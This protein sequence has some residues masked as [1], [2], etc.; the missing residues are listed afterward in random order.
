MMEEKKGRN[1]EEQPRVGKRG[2]DPMHTWRAGLREEG[3][4]RED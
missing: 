2:Q 1:N 3:D 4:P